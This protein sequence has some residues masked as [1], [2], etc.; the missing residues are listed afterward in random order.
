MDFTTLIL[1]T[2]LFLG[3][4]S[5]FTE[6]RGFLHNGLN[7]PTLFKGCNIVRGKCECRQA[8]GTTTPFIYETADDCINDQNGKNDKCGP[9]PCGD[10]ICVQTMKNGYRNWKCLCDGTGS[11]GD[12]C[13]KKCPSRNEE[14]IHSLYYP[15]ACVMEP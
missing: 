1:N 6:D 11:Y 8:W 3:L 2:F 10:G 15:V 7:T 13:E 14:S 9:Q 4:T 5:A 12:R